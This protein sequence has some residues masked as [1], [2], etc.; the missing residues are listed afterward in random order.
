MNF[1]GPLVPPRCSVRDVM[2]AWMTASTTGPP[3]ADSMSA[4]AEVGPIRSTP[5]L[6]ISDSPSGTLIM[7]RPIAPTTISITMFGK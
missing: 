3:T 6:A 1:T 5:T 7:P 4:I 2:A